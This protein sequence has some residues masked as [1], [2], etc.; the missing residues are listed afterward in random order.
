MAT[1]QAAQVD[2]HPA[3]NITPTPAENGTPPPED[4]HVSETLYIQNLNEKVKIDGE[5]RDLSKL[6]CSPLVSFN[7]AQGFTKRVI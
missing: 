7:S 3:Q 2:P 6:T 4:Q 1:T 5:H